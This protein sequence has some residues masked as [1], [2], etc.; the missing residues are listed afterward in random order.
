MVAP[1]SASAQVQRDRH[2]GPHVDVALER[3]KSLRLDRE[4]IRIRRQVVEHVLARRVRRRRPSEAGD[5][6]VIVTSTACITPPVG[7]VTVPCTVP[8]PPSPCALAVGEANSPKAHH[9]RCLQQNACDR[10]TLP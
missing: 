3:L 6:I 10:A 4:V 9:E 7:S 1:A 8:A 5:R 2:A